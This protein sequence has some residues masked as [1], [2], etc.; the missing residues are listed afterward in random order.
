MF[1]YETYMKEKKLFNFKMVKKCEINADGM[2]MVL[3]QA[4]QIIIHII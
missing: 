1:A 4:P 3:A 2:F